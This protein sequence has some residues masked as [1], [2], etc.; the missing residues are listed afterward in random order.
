M[1]SVLRRG[2]VASGVLSTAAF[3]LAVACSEQEPEER[4]EALSKAPSVATLG[5]ASVRLMAKGATLVPVPREK[6]AGDAS[7]SL[8]LELPVRA[9]G[10]LLLRPTT[11][12]EH[13]LQLTP[14]SASNAHAVLASDGS[15]VYERAFG[16]ADLVQSATLDGLRTQIA[17]RDTSAPDLFVWQAA[18][19]QGMRAVPRDD[20][21]TDL[22]DAK[23]EAWLRVS[24]VN[25]VDGQGNVSKVPLFFGDDG[26][27]RLR[28]DPNGLTYPTLIDFEATLGNVQALAVAPTQI[29]GR[30]MVL[31]DTSGS[32]LWHFDDSNSTNGDSP[33]GNGIAQFCDNGL[34]NGSTFA[35]NANKACTIANGALNY[36]PVADN[37]DPSRLLASK[38]ALQNVVNA[39]AGILDFGLERYAES[40]ACPN[41]TNPAYCCNSQTDGATR[42]RCQGVDNYT[43]IPNTGTS[44]DLTYAGS[45]GTPY[46]GGRV[47]IQPGPGS[48]L[49]L[50]PWIDFTEDFCSSTGAVGGAPR[51]PELR[52]SGNTP[53]GKAVR[54]ARETWY[55]PTYTDSK[56]PGA[57]PLDDS[58][59]DCRP[60]VLVVMTDGVDTC[61][62][63]TVHA[64]DCAGSDAQC[65]TNHC[66]SAD[67][68]NSGAAAWGC[69]CTTNTDCPGEGQTCN[70]TAT[71]FDC[72]DS[73]ARCKGTAVCVDT[74]G[75]GDNFRCS[76][77]ADADCG[78]GYVCN[79]GS[80]P[81]VDCRD[82]DARCMSNNCFDAPGAGTNWRC[83]CNNNGQCPASQQ[84]TNGRCVARGICQAAGYCQIDDPAPSE[85]VQSLTAVNNV[86]PVKT[87][88]LGMGDPAGLDVNELNAMA[89]AGGTTQARLAN[90]QAEIEAAFADIVA[91]TVKYE[92]C[93]AKDDNCNARIDEGLGVYQE[94][95]TAAD[96]NGGA[97]N[98][99][100]CVCNGNA[101][102][103][104]GYA[105]SNE[106]PVRFCRPSCS[107]GQGACLVT[108]VRKCGV[109]VGQCCVNDGAATCTDITPP[110]GTA[111][112]CNGIDDNC[113]GFI[114]ENLSCQGCVPLPEVCDGKD[115]DCDGKIDETG[116][117]G[118]VDVG[119]SCGSSVG[120]CKPGTAVCVNG[121][122]GC[123]GGTGPVTEVCNGYDDDCD[124]VVD[125]MTRA[126]Y[127]GPAATRGV[128]TC[129]DGTQ[130]CAVTTPGMPKWGV[131]T[132]DQ[133]PTTEICNGLDDDCDGAVD[134]GVD[135]GNGNVTGKECCGKGVS[136]AQCGQGQCKMG[137]WACAGSVF[138]CENAGTPGNELCD[139][140]DND[141]DGKVDNIPTVGGPCVAPG[142]CSG[143]LTCDSDA[144]MLV[145]K[146]DG[147][148]HVEV[149]DGVDNDCDGKTD[150]IEDVQV[151]DDWWHD[152]CDA[153]P[154]GHDKEPCH[155][156]QYVCKN[157]QKFCE[158]A[159]QP[160]PEVCD[161]KDTDCDGVADTLAACPGEN[162]C[163]Q[164]VCVEPCRGGEFPCPG[165]YV[166]QGFEGK[167][168]CVPTTCN[169]VECPPGASCQEGKC[170]LD[171]T[172]GAPNVEGGAGN[173]VEGGAGS[174][175]EGGAGNVTPEGG[176]SNGATNG[177]GG[178][179]G[180][181]NAGTTTTTTEEPPRGIYGL[182]TGGGGCACRTAP[183]SGG[184]LATFAGLLLV[185]AAMGRRRQSQSRRAR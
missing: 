133:G 85:Q 177:N 73:N 66:F 110:A 112:V 111:E 119:G 59:I 106:A 176:D 20:F 34:A 28:I 72:A 64:R 9:D 38:Q 158:G 164:G 50:L 87:Y 3:L 29:K 37:A 114:D 56:T 16:S 2:F 132:G 60:Y 40:S 170:T 44:N 134:N 183:D 102:C 92:V 182:V 172:G 120:L 181:P 12:P 53:L 95:I 47:L 115:N 4:V 79:T 121:V 107:E 54:T 128:G 136:Q 23:G 109:G 89:V 143:T 69:Q 166:C 171:A 99:G 118:L 8:G 149:C 123:S 185:G 144:Q 138:V 122:P 13:S 142:G 93:N 48:G 36:W 173:M 71:P 86:N 52:G 25:V 14:T 33:R 49:Q 91:N 147:S 139:N 80:N 180:N 105:C 35:C 162:A 130:V 146:P 62:A 76:C 98:A 21:G 141:C 46:V 117:G 108:G 82:D 153:P 97:C 81:E 26:F 154:E 42:G 127:S 78:A 84:C 135:D 10:S 30:V 18:L 150:E 116:P 41:T 90:S 65:T 15:A 168:Y 124:G 178:N 96:C 31:L 167:K 63:G 58:L 68:A 113:N 55:Q 27:A 83:A 169:A 22:V 94:C 125:G 77:T 75:N 160:R 137:K 163:V 6:R 43:D 140:V 155:A 88:V 5:K 157:G 17:L 100:R 7:P 184:K 67:Q 57:Q 74:P 161:L 104:A 32:M 126:C 165:G 1:H 39:N 151:N 101:Q 70:T 145:C 19:G 129:R 61:G 174:V 51:N 45:C 175:V 179:S 152:P 103:G 11:K 159:V 156:G 131:C 148:A 24:P